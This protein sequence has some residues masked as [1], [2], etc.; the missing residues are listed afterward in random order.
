MRAYRH[1][2]RPKVHEGGFIVKGRK[3]KRVI[4]TLWWGDDITAGS[5]V[6]QITAWVEQTAAR[7]S[8][9]KTQINIRTCLD[10]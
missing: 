5:R 10:T 3:V 7:P 8:G 1:R 4:E 2:T 6:S 9:A